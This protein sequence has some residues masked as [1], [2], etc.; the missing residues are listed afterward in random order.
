MNEIALTPFPASDY[1][2]WSRAE[3]AGVARACSRS[4]LAYLVGGLTGQK[5]V[6]LCDIAAEGKIFLHFL[7]CS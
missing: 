6:V 2:F 7:Y 1:C 4:E 5:P 3:A